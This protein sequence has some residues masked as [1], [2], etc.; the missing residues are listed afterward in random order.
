MNSLSHTLEV[1]A[2]IL[3]VDVYIFNSHSPA[4]MERPQPLVHSSCFMC[5]YSPSTSTAYS[6]PNESAS[7]R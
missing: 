1:G 7:V 4:E 3:G 6:S 5:E 2:H